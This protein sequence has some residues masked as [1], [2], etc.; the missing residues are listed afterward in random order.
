MI[1]ALHTDQTDFPNLVAM[2]LSAH[3]KAAGDDVRWFA[4]KV[5]ATI[6]GN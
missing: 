3:H 5:M 6:G 4:A 2:K 1:V